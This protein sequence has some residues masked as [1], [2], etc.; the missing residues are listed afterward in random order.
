MN[1]MEKKAYASGIKEIFDAYGITTK[2]PLTKRALFN[3]SDQQDGG[4][5]TSS[6]T[7]LLLPLIAAGGIGY[8]AYNAGKYGSK[9][10]SAYSNI[11]N[12]MGRS[13]NSII[14]NTKAPAIHDFA[15]NTHY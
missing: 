12:Y 6:L 13:L 8:I 7:K 9:R 3:F 4:G 15:A 11:K 1:N 14:R 10:K 2:A 5:L